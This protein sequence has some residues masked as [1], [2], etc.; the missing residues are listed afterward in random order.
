M[1][2]SNGQPTTQ[3]S[4]DSGT[5]RQQ[6]GVDS[7]EQLSRDHRMGARSKRSRRSHSLSSNANAIY[8]VSIALVAL[9]IPLYSNLDQQPSQPTDPSRLFFPGRFPYIPSVRIE[10]IHLCT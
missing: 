6:M 9:Q 8:P 3:H 5:D 1:E 7:N 4:V 2:C 10:V